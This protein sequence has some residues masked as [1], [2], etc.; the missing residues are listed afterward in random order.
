MP[1]ITERSS[2]VENLK[3]RTSEKIAIAELWLRSY[4]PLKFAKVLP[5][6]CGITIADSKKS[7]TCPPLTF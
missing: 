4:I 1:K 6:S 7:Y 3:L 2:E 5:S